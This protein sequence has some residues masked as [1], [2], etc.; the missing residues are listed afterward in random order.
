MAG[1][2]Y[3]TPPYSVADMEPNVGAPDPMSTATSK[4]DKPSRAKKSGYRAV[5][6]QAVRG[7]PY[8][9]RATLVKPP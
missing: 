2:L 5:M 7:P 3:A 9:I 8:D 4:L 1:C 6:L